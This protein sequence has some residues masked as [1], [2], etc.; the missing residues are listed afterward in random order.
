MK[1][2]YEYVTFVLLI[3]L[4]CLSCLSYKYNNITGNDEM[5]QQSMSQL[6]NK[7]YIKFKNL[8]S[9]SINNIIPTIPGCVKEKYTF[10]R[11]LIFIGVEIIYQIEQE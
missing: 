9:E 3:M 11:L 8:Y 2:L 4:F 5:Y 10:Q 7:D 1:H 6:S